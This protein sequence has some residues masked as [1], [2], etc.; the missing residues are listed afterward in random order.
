MK[1][2]VSIRLTCLFHDWKGCS[3]LE[4]AVT[5]PSVNTTRGLVTGKFSSIHPDVAEFIGIRFGETTAGANRFMPPKR[6][7]GNGPIDAT[8]PGSGCLQAL[9]NGRPSDP[10]AAMMGAKSSED[11]LFMNVWTKTP[12][13]QAKK[14][15]MLW[16]YGGAFTA[17]DSAWPSMNLVNIT[18]NHDI[19][20]VSFNYRLSVFGFPGAPGLEQ[21]NPGLL[22]QRMA[23]EW[24]R[25]NIEAFG[26][27]PQRIT[28]FGESAGGSSVDYYAYAW[29]KDPIVNAFIVQSGTAMMRDLF[30]PATE[31]SEAW[32]QMSQKL[33]CGG[34]EAGKSSLSC[35][36]GKPATELLSSLPPPTSGGF[37]ALVPAFK[38]TVDEKTVF[39]DVYARAKAGNFAQKVCKIYFLKQNHITFDYGAFGN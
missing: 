16:I 31:K 13:A 33:G 26:G 28:L 6:Y 1:S 8:K 37:K 18:G 12:S 38:P 3:A 30:K 5:P 36:R 15:V 25:D 14:P 35:A 17:G 19:V 20:L 29:A 34:P 7:Y 32:F 10:V 11:C 24:T 9:G 27:D 2:S 23:V 22:D 39:S 4:N 21:L